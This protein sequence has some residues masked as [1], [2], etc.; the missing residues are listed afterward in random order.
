MCFGAI[1][2]LKHISTNT[3]IL[4]FNLNNGMRK[5]FFIILTFLLSTT[6]LVAQDNNVSSQIQLKNEASQIAQKLNLDKSTEKL[7]YNVLRH[8][9]NRLEDL[10]FG[11]SN[12]DKLADYINEERTEMMKVI[13]PTKK[14]DE[15]EKIYD[16]G[17][18]AKIE[19]LK[20][21]NNQY[22]KDLKNNNN[23]EQAESEA[24]MQKD[25]VLSEVAE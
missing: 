7:I 24:L 23:P 9:K 13:M 8:I 17:E 19:K 15:Y 16:A 1:L 21:I 11:T 2:T 12:Y 10:P 6:Y 22:I 18:K 5:T 14:Y 4:S 20:A 3:K 25:R